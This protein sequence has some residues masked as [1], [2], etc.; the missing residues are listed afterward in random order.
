MSAFAGSFPL[1][2]GPWRVPPPPFSGNSREKLGPLPP[3][4]WPPAAGRPRGS[5]SGPPVSGT[6]IGSR[7]LIGQE[8][9]GAAPRGLIRNGASPRPEAPTG[10]DERARRKARQKPLGTFFPPS[11]GFFVAKM[12]R[13][14]PPCFEEES[15]PWPFQPGPPGPPR[16]RGHGLC[17]P[18][19][20]RFPRS[21]DRGFREPPLRP[22]LQFFFSAAK[23]RTWG[24]PSALGRPAWKRA[25]RVSLKGRGRPLPVLKRRNRKSPR[26]PS[27]PCG[28]RKLQES[29][30]TAKRAAELT[31]EKRSRRAGARAGPAPRRERRWGRLPVSRSRFPKDGRTNPTSATLPES[32]RPRW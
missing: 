4:E 29:E 25:C 28:G 7:T 3:Y 18:Y 32:A 30:G 5:R 6:G 14:L 21:R 10:R 9:R 13:P 15:S 26:T 17:L 20:R 2:L 16:P 24:V 22:A 12:D 1:F 11:S 19:N 23:K 31:Q 27:L 8:I